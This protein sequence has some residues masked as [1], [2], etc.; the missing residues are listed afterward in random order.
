V[1]ARWRGEPSELDLE[2][3]EQA[4]VSVEV[5]RCVQSVLRQLPIEGVRYQDDHALFYVRLL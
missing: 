4:G 1:R 3:V 5:A 2:I